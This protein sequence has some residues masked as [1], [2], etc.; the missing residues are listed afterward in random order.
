MSVSAQI[1][2]KD[3]CV[4]NLLQ[5][6]EQPDYVS[7]KTETEVEGPGRDVE[8]FTVDHPKLPKILAPQ[9]RFVDLLVI[10]RN[11]IGKLSLHHS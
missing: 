9:N 8:A 1:T 10:L 3:S 2:V 7:T 11:A 4:D 5:G 6:G